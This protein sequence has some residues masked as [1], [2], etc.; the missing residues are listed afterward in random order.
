MTDVVNTF[1]HKFYPP[2][3]VLRNAE[4]D[5]EYMCGSYMT[6]I[7]IDGFTNIFPRM[8]CAD[9]FSMSVQGHYGGYSTPRDDFAESYS[10]VEV[11]FPS[12]VEDLLM[13]YCGDADNPTETVYGYVPISVIEEVI[14]KHG[15]LR[16][17]P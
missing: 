5:V 8:E 12:A 6:R 13:P 10:L 11:G 9:G 3:D 17:D 16:N 15:G 2:G 14:S 1:F 7:R 4:R